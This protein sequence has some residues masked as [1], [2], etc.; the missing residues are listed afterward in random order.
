M[1]ILGIKKRNLFVRFFSIKHWNI[2]VHLNNG[3]KKTY[4]I[5]AGCPEYGHAY[6]VNHA[7]YSLE[8][9]S[10]ED[11]MHQFLMGNPPEG[12]GRLYMAFNE[13]MPPGMGQGVA[14]GVGTGNIVIGVQQNQTQVAT[15]TQVGVRTAAQIQASLRQQTSTRV[16]VGVRHGK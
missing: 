9:M 3:Q 4:P 7:L 11:V 14:A 5:W 1:K 6:S 12:V 8:E 16:G 15:Q 13:V 10:G 2:S